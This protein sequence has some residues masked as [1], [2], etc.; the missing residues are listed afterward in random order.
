MY[1]RVPPP[2]STRN[3]SRSPLFVK[4]P[5]TVSK[6]LL[7]EKDKAGEKIVIDKLSQ[8]RSEK[9][10]EDGWMDGWNL[11]DGEA[12]GDDVYAVF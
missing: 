1:A 8:G 10:Q 9:N 3:L 5:P 2:P 12:N 11:D 6:N 7:C 4:A